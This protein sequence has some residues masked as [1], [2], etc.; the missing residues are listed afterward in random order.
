MTTTTLTSNGSRRTLAAEIDR[1]DDILDGLSNSLSEAVADAIKTTA[2]QELRQAAREAVREALAQRGEERVT[3]QSA[4]RNPTAAPVP[5]GGRLVH[6]AAWVEGW[7]A[8]WGH[9]FRHV[10]GRTGAF[11]NQ[12]AQAGRAGLTQLGALALLLLA[13]LWQWRWHLLLAAGAGLM[14]G[15]LT[16]LAGPWLGVLVAGASGFGLTLRLALRLAPRPVP[17]GLDR[18][19]DPTAA[20]QI[21]VPSLGG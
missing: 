16:L 21:S 10:R 1:L 17:A 11:V 3:A 15:L 20:R 8:R 14:L 19:P 18:T 9:S 4:N 6:L 12:V 13:L 5:A 7:A 2:G